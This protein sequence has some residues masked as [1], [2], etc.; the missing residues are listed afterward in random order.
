MATVD[1]LREDIN[2]IRSAVDAL[3]VTL[4]AVAPALATLASA[5]AEITKNLNDL[6]DP[7]ESGGDDSITFGLDL[8]TTSSIKV[9]WSTGRVDVK[10]WEIGRN[11]ADS[12]GSG[13]WKTT[14]AADVHEL[15]FNS[16]LT[17]TPYDL[18]LVPIFTDNSRGDALVLNT[19]TSGTAGGGGTGNGN[20]VTAAAKF[21]WGTPDPISDEFPV[22]GRPDPNKW[23]Y[24]GDYG[25]GWEGHTGNGR[26]MPENTF[27]KDGL[28]VMRGDGNG[29]T[30]WL[31]Q[32]KKVKYGR[33][34]IRSRSRNTGSSGSTYH[35]LHLIWPS[36]DD[37]PTL[38]ELDFV[39][40]TDPDSKTAGAWL[41]YPH[42]KGIAIQQ[43]GPFTK[44]CD[45]T[46]FHAFAFEWSPTGVRAWIDGEPWYEVKDGGGPLGRKNIQDMPLGALTIQLDAFAK[47]NLRPA[48]FEV[49]WVRFYPYLA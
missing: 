39:E 20:G 47:S 43:A 26:R 44:S 36:P 33:W 23:S 8:I 12:Q 27:V 19:R 37:W 6:E 16:L 14:V 3:S 9:V 22:D 34:E 38:G 2:Q 11:G 41:H 21:G 35:P 40:Y 29:N 15:T 31:R 17:G 1:D 46:Q 4:A 10:N 42:K 28:L 45:M 25:V 24:C 48:V 5:I 13:P 18:T 30:G 7:D 32:K 49:D